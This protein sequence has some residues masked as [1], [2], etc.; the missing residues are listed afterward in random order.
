ML[1]RKTLNFC[2]LHIPRAG[3]TADKTVGSP[4][5]WHGSF[6]LLGT[7]PLPSLGTHLTNSHTYLTQFKRHLLSTASLIP[8]LP[9]GLHPTCGPYCV[10]LESGLDAA[11]TPR[12]DYALLRAGAAS[13]LPGLSHSVKLWGWHG[14]RAR[15]AWMDERTQVTALTIFSS[16]VTRAQLRWL[17]GLP[18]C[19]PPARRAG[20][21][22]TAGK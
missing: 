14:R 20:K 5:L 6:V 9:P 19:P 10:S 8:P 2:C 1:L 7:P 13:D 3:V 11:K 18:R 17:P 12:S 21:L 22:P 16:R 4:V 15:T